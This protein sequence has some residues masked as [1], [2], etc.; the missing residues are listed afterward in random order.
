MIVQDKHAGLAQPD[1]CNLA[2]LRGESP[3]TSVNR[4][5]RLGW[6]DCCEKRIREVVVEIDRC[7][8]DADYDNGVQKL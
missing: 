3:F 1:H 7:L 2:Y 4:A 5:G 6:G 8:I